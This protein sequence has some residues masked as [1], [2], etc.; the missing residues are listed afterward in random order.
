LNYINQEL[1]E[2]RGKLDCEVK[3]AAN[4]IWRKFYHKTFYDWRCSEK[5]L[6]QA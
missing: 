5:T 4:N 3:E 1:D 2:E 6:K